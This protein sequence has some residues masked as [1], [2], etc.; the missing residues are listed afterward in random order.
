MFKITGV[1]FEYI[2]YDK[3]GNEIDEHICSYLP[4]NWNDQDLIIAKLRCKID[5]LFYDIEPILEMTLMNKREA[6]YDEDIIENLS[7]KIDNTIEQMHIDIKKNEDN[8]V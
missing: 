5:T 3:F 7:I 6:Y 2:Q 4:K 1:D 8:N